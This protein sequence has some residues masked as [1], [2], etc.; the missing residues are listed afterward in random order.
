[1]Q[2]F[3]LFT[4]FSNRHWK[5]LTWIQRQYPNRTNLLKTIP[6][7]IIPKQKLLQF[8]WNKIIVIPIVIVVARNQQLRSIHLTQFLQKPGISIYFRTV[9]H[10]ITRPNTQVDLIFVN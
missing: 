8:L 4:S 9:I 5:I 3:P 10:Q 2:K 6:R 7:L 1:M